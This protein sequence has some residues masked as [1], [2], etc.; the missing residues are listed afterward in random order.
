LILRNHDCF[1]ALLLYLYAVKTVEIA[2]QQA[3]RAIEAQRPKDVPLAEFLRTV[4]DSFSPE[5]ST[6]SEE[7]AAKARVLARGVLAR[8]ELEQ[9][10]GGSL[11][12]DH[13]AELLGLNKRQSVDYQRKE[14][15]LVAWRTSTGKWRYPAWQFTKHGILPGIKECLQALQTDNGFGAA[16]FF[17]TDRF[18]LGEKRPLDLLREGKINEAVSAARRHHHHGAH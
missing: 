1:F 10:E 17:L 18:S 8:K 15:H 5:S 6:T 4:I 14:R 2:V 7:D 3:H 16:I 12:S 13:V 11:S 9:A